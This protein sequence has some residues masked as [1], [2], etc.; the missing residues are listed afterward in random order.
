MKKLFKHA[1]AAISTFAVITA[2]TLPASA[3]S[4]WVFGNSNNCG[5]ALNAA[6]NSINCNTNVFGNCSNLSD[7]LSL[8]RSLTS[9]NCFGNSNGNTNSENNSCNTPDCADTADTDSDDNSC[10]TPDCAAP[11]TSDN[12]PGNTN[13]KPDVPAQDNTTAKPDT[14][15]TDKSV[16]EYEKKVAELVNVE[17]AKYGLSALTLNTGLSSIARAKSQDMSDKHYF[18][19]TSPTYGSAFDMMKSAGIKYNTAGENIAYGYRT[20][21]SVVNGWMNSEGHRAN[22][23]NSSYKEIGVGYVASGNYWTQMFIG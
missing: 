9:G 10:N 17:R 19:H 13:S 5:S 23:L 1:V 18:S 22:I 14:S 16:S 15:T 12:T 4:L 20:P 7:L 21:E 2:S 8:L 6:S 11:D 3:A